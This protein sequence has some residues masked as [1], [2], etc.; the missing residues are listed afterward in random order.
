MLRT[1]HAIQLLSLK[2]LLNL[3]LAATGLRV[4][5][6]KSYIMPVN[7]D[8]QRLQLLANTLGCATDSLPFAYLG[9][10]LGTSRTSVQDLT[11]IVDQM[12]HK[13]NASAT[14]SLWWQTTAG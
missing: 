11:P 3:F 10:S 4:N 1:H 14:Q 2:E 5:Y 6:S 8:E 13:L 9:L 12:E 7:I